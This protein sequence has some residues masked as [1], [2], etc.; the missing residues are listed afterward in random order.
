MD[1]NEVDRILERIKNETK[2]ADK[3]IEMLKGTPAENQI[4]AYVLGI[5]FAYNV[6]M[7]KEAKSIFDI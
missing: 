6:I 5:M 2:K 1:T 3:Q 4:K 7:G